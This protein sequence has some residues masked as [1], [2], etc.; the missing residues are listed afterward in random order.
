LTEI[1]ILIPTYWTWGSEQHHRPVET[2]FD[3]PTPVDGESTLPRLLNSLCHVV[4]PPFAVWVLMATAHRA[5][6]QVAEQRAIEIIAPF[7]KRFP[8][9]LFAASELA[10]LHRRI[11]N[12]CQA[13]LV[14]LF[15][16]RSYAGMRNCQL[17]I[18]CA[19]GAEV[20]VALD[21][22]EVI[23]P[24]Y[25]ET[26]LHF[27][28][29]EQDGGQRVLGV[30]GLY[31]NANGGVLLPENPRTGNIFLDK[32]AVMNEG[33]RALQRTV[34]RLV[35]TPF[36]FGGNMVFHRDLLTRVGF[37]IGITR[38][39]DIDYL[40]NARLAGHCFWLDK[41]LL[42]THL[43][44]KAYNTHPYA[45]LAQDVARFIY[46]R[47]KLGMANVYLAQFD[48]YPGRFLRDGVAT[49]ALAALEGLATAEAVDRF[50]APQEIVETAERS[51]RETSLRYFELAAR[52]PDLIK[53]IAQDAE[54]RDWLLACFDHPA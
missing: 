46:E 38:G 10:V 11:R 47:E 16:L 6:E 40:I 1:V 29:S 45:R 24:D 9:A 21:D 35:D 42:V 15:S 17:V 27:I 34:G 31:L 54:L 39:E 30:T 2:I 28:G 7:R 53:A 22:D 43:P 51:A 26:A 33:M 12:S 25:L 5:L 19:L 20:A 8:I 32:S 44:P 49:Q 4:G 14:S 52:W 23:A 36:A 41:E 13:E 48:P 37:D 50:G 18:P 3:H